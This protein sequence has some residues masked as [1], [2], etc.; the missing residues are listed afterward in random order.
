MNKYVESGQ[1]LR[2]IVTLQCAYRGP[3]LGLGQPYLAL[4]KGT[5]HP[6]QKKK[7][8]VRIPPGY[9]ILKEIIA[10][11]QMIDL[12]WLCFHLRNK[13]IGRN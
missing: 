2:N 8:R 11:V 6:P 9:K 1:M 7:T 12:H 3:D 5:S 4:A 13:G 10:C